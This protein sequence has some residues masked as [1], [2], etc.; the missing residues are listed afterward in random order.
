MTDHQKSK[1]LTG[2]FYTPAYVVDFM[3]DR[4]FHHLQLEGRISST[5]F[6]HFQKSLSSLSFCDPSLGNGNFVIGILKRVWGELQK[7]S[8]IK[9][10]EK[11]M[12]FKDFY[13]SNIYGIE[14]T[15]K[16]LEECKERISFFYPILRNCSSTNLKLG[17]SIVNTDVSEIL[18]S[19]DSS[20]LK[21]FNWKKE[22]H[23]RES[24]DIIIGNPPYYNLKKTELLDNKANL[25]FQYLKKSKIWKEYYRSSS[26]IYYYFIF[27]ALNHL[28]FNGLLSFIIPNYW[29]ENRYADILRE[30]ILSNQIIELLD[31]RNIRIFKDNGKWLNVTNCITLIQ[32]R[33]PTNKI[34]IAR[35]I[36]K[37][38]L[39]NPN[40]N[41]GTLN[42]YVFEID[43]TSLTREKWVLSPHLSIL[44]KLA[45]D[46]R[47]T[48]LEHLAKIVQ[49][50]SPGVKDVF[51]MLQSKA[52]KLGL[53][54]DVLV[55]FI[56]NKNVKKWLVENNDSKLAI[57]PSRIDDLSAYFNV[58]KYLEQNRDVLVEG[59]DRKRLL[60]SERIRWF[61][62]SVYRNIDTF[63]QHKEK[64][65]VPYRAL[66]PRFGLDENG[67]FG[68]TDIYAIVPKKKSDLY[69]LLGV[70]NSDIVHFWY[71]EAGKRKGNMLEFFS[72]PLK[73]IPIPKTNDK[74]KLSSLVKTIIQLTRNSHNNEKEITKVSESINVEV[75]R[76]YDVDYSLIKSNLS[77]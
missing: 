73:R 22:F 45:D 9:Q 46:N 55:P 59:S 41:K 61:D 44:K 53:E 54:K 30:H 3:V 48:N 21:P 19:Q 23:P 26:D 65:I 29:I 57:L 2:S 34:K 37:V 1:K 28:N 14:L 67:S 60:S 51:V 27:Q 68:A 70:L 36:P 10:E 31:L 47:T 32:K 12:F 24:F 58:E 11:N 18:S 71:S 25:L 17:N 72:D 75:A 43:Q 77:T 13:E 35:N 16:A 76:L 39:E 6:K 38:Y 42:K 5:S 52:D 50:L 74:T 66:T 40:K 56:S 7:F 64:I 33:P 4:V 8:S 15:P 49:G 62:F 63:N 69:F 20:Q